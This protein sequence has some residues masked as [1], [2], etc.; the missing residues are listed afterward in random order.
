VNIVIFGA[1]S[2]IAQAVARLAAARGDK[3]CLVGR[4]SEKLAIVGRDLEARGAQAVRSVKADLLSQESV[5]KAL[6]MG[7]EFLERLDVVLIA[8]GLLPDQVACENRPELVEEC[9]RINFL[10]PVMIADAA[11]KVLSKLG[12]GALVVIGSVA[13]DRGRKSLY[14]YSAAKGGLERYVQGLR[15]RLHSTGIRVVLIK[16]GIVDTP[17][18][19]HLRKGLLMAQPETVARRIVRSFTQGP[20]TVYTP[21]IWR[22][23]MTVIKSIPEGIFKKLPL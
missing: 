3:F 12:Q 6:G 15:G 2:G 23:I 14:Y 20:E 13:G 5:E 17:M 22:L 11:I 9:L 1:T 21:G 10:S 16:P 8:H 19:A 7:V 18:T 4:N